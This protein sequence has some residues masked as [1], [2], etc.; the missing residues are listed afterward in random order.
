MWRSCPPE[1]KSN[2]ETE[3]ILLLRNRSF[4]ILSQIPATE[5]IFSQFDSH[6]LQA[7]N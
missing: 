3:D 1:E 6:I 2:S 7:Y 4:I 5:L